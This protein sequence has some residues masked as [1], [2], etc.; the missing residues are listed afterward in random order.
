MPRTIQPELLDT[1]SPQHPD[2]IHSRRD[3]RILNRVMGNHRWIERVLLKNLR[4]GEHVLEIGAGTGELAQR[5]NQST[6]VDA[7][8]L[9]PPPEDWPATAN[10][11]SADLKSFDAFRDY[12]VI[13][14]NLIFHHFADDELATLGEK[15]RSHARMIIA[16]EPVR[17]PLSQWLLRLFAPLFGASNVTMHDGL[18]SI[19][20]GFSGDELPVALGLNSRDWHVERT[21]ALL[22][23]YRMIAT[24]RA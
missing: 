16:C 18:V 19:A 14:G 3:L 17:R 13:V 23:G 1:L 9:V 10:W 7:I 8:D 5:L 20:G 12:P 22:G 21:H 2:A 15:L 4:Q 11:Y 24:R 6:Q